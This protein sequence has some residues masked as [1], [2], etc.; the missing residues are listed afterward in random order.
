MRAELCLSTVEVA[1][2]D[3]LLG[4]K[5]REPVPVVLT[6]Q[7]ASGYRYGRRSALHPWVQSV[8][9][10]AVILVGHHCWQCGALGAQLLRGFVVG[11]VDYIGNGV[12]RM[13]VL[14]TSASSSSVSMSLKSSSQ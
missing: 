4:V 6:C 1:S 2:D 10:L 9:P 3:R 12:L 5:G 14:A 11:H 8:W 13:H 7:K